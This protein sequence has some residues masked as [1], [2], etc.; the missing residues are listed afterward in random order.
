M[1]VNQYVPFLHHISQTKI[2]ERI[3]ERKIS[4]ANLLTSLVNL[5]LVVFFS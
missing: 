5:F 3:T 1:N 4:L 2:L